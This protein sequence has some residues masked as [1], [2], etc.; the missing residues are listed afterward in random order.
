MTDLT[1][2]LVQKV[3]VD[4]KHTSRLNK[5]QP[6]GLIL[7]DISSFMHHLFISAIVR[8]VMIDRALKKVNLFVTG[9]EGQ[10]LT[11]SLSVAIGPANTQ[12]VSIVKAQHFLDVAA[13]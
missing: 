6:K 4:L 10:H 12:G 13:P 11:V 5:G 9:E 3:L 8:H 7:S 1:T 2:D